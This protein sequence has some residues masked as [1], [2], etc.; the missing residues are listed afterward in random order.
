[1]DW[2]TAKGSKNVNIMNKVYSC[3]HSHINSLIY[4]CYQ[5]L[6]PVRLCF[7]I[8]DGGEVYSIQLYVIKFVSDLQRLGGFSQVTLISSTNTTDN[9][10]IVCLLFM[11]FNATLNNISVISWQSVLLVEETRVLGENHRPVASHW[12]TLSHNVVHLALIEIRM[13]TLLYI[14]LTEMLFILSL[15]IH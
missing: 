2:T 4:I 12:Q 5:W 13:T 3:G 9:I 10:D 1:M 11:V 6:S 14:L 15:N 8:P 7:L